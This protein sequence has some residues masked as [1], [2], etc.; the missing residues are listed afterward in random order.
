MSGLALKIF[1]NDM[2]FLCTSCNIDILL[3]RTLT[4]QV[5]FVSLNKKLAV[6]AAK[7]LKNVSV[8]V[9]DL[10]NYT[11]PLYG[12]DEEMDRLLQKI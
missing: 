5:S 11:L 2:W 12:I 4:T 8:A 10:N 6:F 9:L 1:L 3:F 7:Q